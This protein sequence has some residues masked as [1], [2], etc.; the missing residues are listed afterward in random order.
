[1]ADLQA[2]PHA[3]TELLDWLR[4]NGPRN[5]ISVRDDLLAA[6]TLR[7]LADRAQSVVLALQDLKEWHAAASF[8]EAAKDILVRWQDFAERSRPLSLTAP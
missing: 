4:K 2:L 1:M 7:E 5:T 3:R 8:W 6:R